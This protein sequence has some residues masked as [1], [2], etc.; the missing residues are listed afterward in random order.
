MVTI[1]LTE[2]DQISQ[3][4]NSGTLARNQLPSGTKVIIGSPIGYVPNAATEI[5]GNNQ[6]IDG[7]DV[8][9][10]G[11][12]LNQGDI[13][14]ID[15]DAQDNDGNGAIPNPSRNALPS[16]FQNDPDTARFAGRPN[17]L[18]SVIRV[19]NANG[20]E[21]ARAQ[22]DTRPVAFKDDPSSTGDAA[23]VFQAPSTGVFYIGVG[24]Q[25][26][27]SY[28]PNRAPNN[29]APRRDPGGLGAVGAFQLELTRFNPPNVDIGDVTRLEGTGGQNLFQFAVTL[30]QPS[31]L[32][33]TI[34]YQTG[35]G[36]A[37]AGRDYNPASGSLTFAPGE[38]R[39][40]ITVPIITDNTTENNEWFSVDLS[41]ATNG[42]IITKS[43]GVGTI[44]NDDVPTF[45]IN[46]V[47][48]IEGDTNSFRMA[49]F[50][51]E[52]SPIETDEEYTVNVITEDITAITRSDYNP[53]IGDSLT[54]NR[55][56]LRHS[57]PV[58][59]IGDE[60]VEPDEQFRLRLFNP[61][62]GAVVGRESGIATILNDD[63]ATLSISNASVAEGSR[64][65]Q[66]LM[67]FQISSDNLASEDMT[68]R[69]S[70]SPNLT[71]NGATPGV[72]FVPLSNQLVTIPAGERFANVTVTVNGDAEVEDDESVS[73]TLSD[74][75]FR[76]SVD[77][78]RV[79]LGQE[80]GR[81]V[82]INDDVAVL[83]VEDASVIEG[84]E[85]LSEIIFTI[86]SN[87]VA[88]KDI[89][90]TV[91]T[92]AV[93]GN[94]AAIPGEDFIAIESQEVTIRAG[95]QA[96]TV[97]VNVVGDRL[98]EADE[99]FSLRIL[100]EAQFDGMADTSRVRI[101]RREGQGTIVNDDKRSGP[102]AYWDLS[103]N[104]STTAADHIR[105]QGENVDGT[106]RND[107]LIGQEG[108]IPNNPSA[109]FDG[110]NDYVEV[111]HNDIFQLPRGSIQFWFKPEDIRRK[112]GLISRDQIGVG[113][114]GD[115]TVW[116]QNGEIVVR[117]QVQGEPP[118][119]LFRGGAVRP[120][121]WN[122]LVI[123]FGGQNT[124]GEDNGMS[125]YLNGE[126]VID[127]P[128]WVQ[129]WNGDKRPLIFGAS[130]EFRRNQPNSQP[131]HYFRGWLDEIAL[132]DRRLSPEEILELFNNGRVTPIY[133][134]YD[135]HS[136]ITLGEPITF[137]TS[138]SETL[139]PPLLD[140]PNLMRGTEQ[141]DIIRGTRGE[142]DIRGL[143]GNDRLFGG[144]GD[145]II[146]GGSG[147]D[148]ID[149]GF[150]DNVITTGAGSDLIVLR[151]EQGFQ[152]VLDFRPNRDMIELAGVR[153]GQ[154]TIR[155]Q[156]D[157]TLIKLGDTNVMLLENTDA[158]LISRSDFLQA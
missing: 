21:I 18:D 110:I 89:T 36:T 55:D 6:A 71:P 62:N 50:E 131:S 107:V 109:F 7:S 32:A 9:L 5:I 67:V 54:F 140:R 25:G 75:R 108:V 51:I 29:D 152:R 13:I 48:V 76:E 143:A 3:V 157:N 30:S 119:I 33:H 98:F 145:D 128:N 133:D 127:A 99:V 44:L 58:G 73:L 78:S 24:A 27:E 87:A 19:F 158:S 82:I 125:A 93:N 115:F 2:G 135:F 105:H 123:N 100:G 106:Y 111:Q 151:G 49:V 122:F 90:F 28:N 144:A 92:A 56:T 53:R 42:A 139:A 103:D 63:V 59:I 10:Y 61:T 72:D 38:T 65:S 11:V 120:G 137:N 146:Y 12:R 46:D 154:L 66:S 113:V 16:R 95:Q 69:V 118:N 130:Q 134:V 70:T 147:N 124:E 22:D 149:G 153:F 20:T 81:G 88:S 79:I 74:P 94:N 35:D 97:T 1:N 112:Q 4:G 45:T 117:S 85:G 83:S 57:F 86:S 121:N 155:Q 26:N 39:K 104:D 101:G 126:L 8:D 68:V 23:L 64:G 114:G 138:P 52:M 14:I 141:D 129:G 102:I 15:V 132:F 116:V 142:D 150:G 77:T 96:A 47:T 91:E 17:R 34:S 156:Q 136:G 37:N 31:P 43:R 148:R 80:T 60:I 84:N 41:G 40:V